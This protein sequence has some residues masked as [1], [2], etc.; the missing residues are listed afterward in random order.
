MSKLATKFVIIAMFLVL[1]CL[2]GCFAELGAKADRG[3]DYLANQAENM[4]TNSATNDLSQVIMKHAFEEHGPM[5]TK[6]VEAC[7][8]EKGKVFTLKHMYTL[9]KANPTLGKKAITAFLNYPVNG[10][11]R[12][13]DFDT[14]EYEA[15]SDFLEKDEAKMKGILEG[16]NPLTKTKKAK[17]TTTSHLK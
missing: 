8:M 1:P 13:K 4:L 12:F 14:K 9:Y 17:K 11:H 16:K 10:D 2:G 7:G 5:A 6:V 15:L 3:M